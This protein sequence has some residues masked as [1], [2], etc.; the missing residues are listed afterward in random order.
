[1]LV[2]Y[3]Y[4]FLFSQVN[5]ANSVIRKNLQYEPG[6]NHI[7]CFFHI[8][9]NNIFHTTCS[10]ASDIFWAILAIGFLGDSITTGYFN[11]FGLEEQ[12]RGYTRWFCG[13][14]PTLICATGTRVLAFGIIF[15]LYSLIIRYDS[16]W[17]IN[18]IRMSVLMTPIV[19]GLMAI[20]A[21]AINSYAM[22]R[23]SR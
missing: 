7:G 9:I 19:F 10:G 4:S 22:W 1:M 13:A 2:L 14:E 16:L 17:E 18:Y 23:V 5:G 11:K 8:R 3:V 6:Y 12:E 21:T 15:G 20:G